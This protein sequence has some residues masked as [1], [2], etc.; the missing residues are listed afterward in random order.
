ML[1]V[2][3]HVAQDSLR[4]GRLQ[5]FQW[6]CHTVTFRGFP[7]RRTTASTHDSIQVQVAGQIWTASRP[8]ILQ[9]S[10]DRESTEN[11]GA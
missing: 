3:T 8:C 4:C 7:D 10:L 11:S 6:Q 2:T 9:Q 5:L 1:A